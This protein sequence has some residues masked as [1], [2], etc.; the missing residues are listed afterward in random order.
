MRSTL[1]LLALTCVPVFCQDAATAPPPPD[2]SSSVEVSAPSAVVTPLPPPKTLTFPP[3]PAICSIPLL[4]AVAPGKPVS[5]PNL[6]PKGRQ[7]APAPADRMSVVAPAPACSATV[8]K[9]A[10]AEKTTPAKP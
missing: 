1:V 6:W 7:F 9:A 4:N 2:N 8:R 10:P 5:M 3:A